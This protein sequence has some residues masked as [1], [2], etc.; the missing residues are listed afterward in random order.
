[1]GGGGNITSALLRRTVLE[2]VEVMDTDQSGNIEKEEFYK[3]FSTFDE[4]ALNDSQLEAMFEAFDVSQDGHISCDEFAK[5]IET[6]V[7]EYKAQEHIGAEN[8]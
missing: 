5:A 8:K 4:L 2:W 6:A 3:F 7:D 1:M